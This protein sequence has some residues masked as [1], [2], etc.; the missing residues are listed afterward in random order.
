MTPIQPLTYVLLALLAGNKP[1]ADALDCVPTDMYWKAHGT[2][3]TVEILKGSLE[4]N[5]ALPATVDQDI[6]DL[7]SESYQTRVR[8]RQHLEAAGPGVVE[9][10]KPLMHGG[11]PDVAEAATELVQKFSASAHGMEVRRLMAIRTLG[12]KKEASALPLLKGLVGSKE[13]FVGEYASRAAAAIEGKGYAWASHE[14]EAAG[15]VQF[16]PKGAGI[17]G[18]LGMLGLDA[19]SVEQIAGDTEA[20]AQQWGRQL[21]PGAPAVTNAAHDVAVREMVDFF[22]RVGDFRVDGVTL[23]VDGKLEWTEVMIHG[24]YSAANVEAAMPGVKVEKV[25]GEDVMR[26]DGTT[27]LVLPG[28][29]R[30]VVV[31]AMAPTSGAVEEAV[32]ALKDPKG[33]GLAGNGP[34]SAAVQG[35]DKSGPGWAVCEVTDGMKGVPLFA[36]I[37][38][39][40]LESKRGADGGVD[41]TIHGKGGGESGDE[42]KVKSAT[43]MFN[44]GVTGLSGELTA[45]I[46]RDAWEAPGLSPLADTLKSLQAKAEDGGA[47]ATGK[48]GHE[49]TRFFVMG[50]GSGMF[51][52]ARESQD[53]AATQP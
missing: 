53:A 39:L 48:L 28:D 8:A 31:A 27:A 44:Q 13:P 29:D 15:D 14:K 23:A 25:Q 9:K 26:L 46:T 35:V 11:D 20:F 42:A 4:V 7:G 37:A 2:A 3:P 41:F 30:L 17:V 24:A 50:S 18:Q 21:R 33:A 1:G 47:T 6:R 51:Q 36:G 5:G 32:A 34:L 52:E 49:M 10:L 16:A 38:A 43:D 40:T 19:L 22:D 12:E 45:E